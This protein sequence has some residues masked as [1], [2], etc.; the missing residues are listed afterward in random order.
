MGKKQEPLDIQTLYESALSHHQ[1][2][3]IEQAIHFYSQVAA[4][5]P[6]VAG[7]HYNLGLAHFEL[8][9]FAEAVNAYSKAAELNPEDPDIFY[10]LGLACKKAGRHSEAEQAYLKALALTPDDHDILYNLGCCYLEAGSIEHARKTFEALTD[11]EPDRVSALNNLAYIN[12]LLGNYDRAKELYK[13]VVELDPGRQ[14]AQY[15]YSVLNGSTE[16]A[17]PREYIRELFDRYS[18]SYD[19]CLVENLECSLYNTMRKIFDETTPEKSVYEH[20]L[21]LGCGT[22]L[23]GEAFRSACRRLDGVDLSRKMIERARSKNIY[24]DLHCNDIIE[25]LHESGKTFDLMIAADVLPYLG[26]LGP[27]FEAAA[28]KSTDDTIF[29]FSS[30]AAM[31]PEW[32]LQS[33]GRYAHHPGYIQKTAEQTGWTVLQESQADIRKEKDQW[34]KGHIFVLGRQ[35]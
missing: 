2:G 7:I 16:K 35:D 22:G 6:E 30:E 33:S 32:V 15:M 10:N 27:L 18:E 3:D 29:C 19:Q 24:D 21:D 8:A 26:D 11:L 25:F 1:Q 34:V 14:S 31:K 20:G 28:S 4:C 17:P 13:Q 12:H 5:V 9:Q 23:T